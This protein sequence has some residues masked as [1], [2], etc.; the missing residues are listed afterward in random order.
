MHVDYHN[1]YINACLMSYFYI[2]VTSVRENQGESGNFKLTF[3]NQGKSGKI[4]LFEEN[5]GKIREFHFESGKK[6]GN[7]VII[8]AWYF[9]GFLKKISLAPSALACYIYFLNILSRSIGARIFIESSY[10]L[11]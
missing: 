11:L 5:Q 4:A 1:K 6:S 7:F 2:R 10:R 8:F 9:L 3:S